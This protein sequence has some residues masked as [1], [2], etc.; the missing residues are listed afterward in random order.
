MS[1]LNQQWE[2]FTPPSRDNVPHRHSTRKWAIIIGG[3]ILFLILA[4]IAKGIYT[5]WLWFGSLG[6]QQVYA[7]VLSTEVWLFAAG[8][9]VFLGLF[10]ANLA[11]VRRFSSPKGEAVFL[12]KTL[13]VMRRVFE[14][15]VW[16][17]AL[18]ASLIFGAIASG[19][20]ETVLKFMHSASF[21]APDPLFG[22]DIGFFVFGL[23]LYRFL[24]GWGIAV[25]VVILVFTLVIYAANLGFRRDVFTSAVKGH[26]SALGAII[27]LFIAWSYRL[28][29]FSLVYSGR[30]VVFGASYAD[31]HAEWVALN[32][33]TVIAILCALVFIFNIFRRGMKLPL[34]GMGIWLAALIVVGGIYPA[35]VQKFW[36]EPNELVKETPY[37]ERNIAMT[38]MAY[39]LDGIQEREFQA[40][41]APSE[42]DIQNNPATMNNI[43]LWDYRPL[44][45]TYNQIQT[46]RLYYDFHDLDV[47][48]YTVDGEY[49]QVMLGARELLPE[50]L[51][52]KAQTWVNQRLQFTH[53][54]GVALSPVNEVSAEGLPELWVK[55]VPP[56][57]SIEISRPEI[58][59]G[60]KTSNYVLVNT[61][62]QEFNYPRG[63]TNEWTRY[64]GE[65]GVKLS[66]FFR[67][68]VY[69]WQFADINILLSGELTPE[70]RVLYYR[71]IGERVSHLAPFLTLDGDPYMVI[72]DG[73]LLWIQDAYTTTDRYPYSQPF[74]SRFNYIRNSAK[75][76]IDAYNGSV[77]FYLADPS[78]ALVNTYASIF[79]GM[80]IPLEQMPSSLRTHLRYPQGLFSVQAELYQSYHMQDAR[81]FYNKEDLWAIPSE[82]YGGVEQP[83]EPYYVI[84]Q[85]PGEEG[86]EFLMMLPFTPTHK[87]NMISWLAA[88][89]DGEQY[90]KLLVYKFPKD[91]LIYGPRQIEARID[92]NTL[93]S[94]QF[95]L[96]G[97]SGSQVIR[98]NMLVIPIGESILYVEPI[99]LRAERGQLPELKRVVVASG[100][101]IVM[102]PTL[103]ES[104][105]VIYEGLAL[106]TQPPA[107]GAVTIPPPAAQP[108][109]SDVARL[110]EEAWKHYAKARENYASGDW[111]GYG[112]EMGKFEQLYKQLLELIESGG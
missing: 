60:E 90:G 18:L 7:T 45:D 43:R 12:G 92:Q 46:I 101:T 85:L 64:Q 37:I 84:M 68:L 33:L 36:V 53:G 107:G 94:E 87:D 29:I 95:T 89:C 57:G 91:K 28:D 15:G 14:I 26:L 83:M 79:P 2:R 99:Y 20:W 10:A 51:T 102:E 63:D 62:T 67:K 52:A 81:V 75:V 88:R 3:V 80:F 49:R 103:N 93:I 72:A 19:R 112:E 69:A 31:V 6:Y 17:A 76:V 9:L 41:A 59:Y 55:D 86:E 48:R 38:R 22:K 96:W 23:P 105:S 54:Y 97:Q 24:Q 5:E 70:S 39:G 32:I 61:R 8:A 108:T 44:K 73:K 47:D 11:L 66:S 111:A 56:V 82:I 58:Y 74:S 50:K 42:G 1:F 104:L 71:N 21:N 30:G 4:S 100:T 16:I 109:S 98:G 35:I 110:A 77:T 25:V 40:E 106:L 65:G 27:F 78:D 13:I 34:W